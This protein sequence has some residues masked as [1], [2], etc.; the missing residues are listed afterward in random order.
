VALRVLE[1]VERSRAFADLALH[2][3]L[4]RGS[5]PAPDRALATELVYGTLRW[6]GRLDWLLS[7]LL[8]RELAK[9]EPLVANALRL[10]AYQIVFADRV[11]ESAAVDESVRCVRALG[12]ERAT[13]LVNAVLRRLAREHHEL[14][15][16]RLEDDPLAHLVHALSLPA[17]LAERWL[18]VF[19]A[20]EAAALARASNEAPRLTVRANRTRVSAAEL[21]ERLRAT[22][23]AARRCS[24]APDGIA[25]GRRGNPTH[26]PAFIGGEYTVQDE[27]SQLVV[28]LLDPQP[29]DRVLD[30]CAAPGTKTTAIAERLA[31][32]GEILALD[33][34]PRRLGL[35]SRDLRRLGLDGVRALRFDATQSL[36]G[37]APDG[38]FDRALVDA[39]CS[40]L[41][42]LRRNPD[43]RWRLRPSDPLELARTQLAL[44]GR[45]AAALR[46]GGTLV[47]STCTL[48]PEEN[49]RVLASFLGENDAFRRTPPGALPA[50]LGPLLDP[51]GSMRTLPH[52]HDADGFFAAR[53]ERVR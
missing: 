19:G 27:A 11:P 35:L 28:E 30:A 13:G 26:D 52:R 14:A 9:L 4:A 41:G 32:R 53:L 47:Y 1:R 2:A 16:P 37:L 7:R 42:A 40:G 46:V 33:R 3:H 31:G 24:F 51:E 22:F 18:D 6:R 36:E 10:G 29:G 5:L 48:L 15:L 43:A 23:P 39:P 45:A 12:A 44:L 34:N 38:G 50:R 8:E 49:E 25:L 21:L 17:W 20:D